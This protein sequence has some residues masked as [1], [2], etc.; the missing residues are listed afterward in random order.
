MGQATHDLGIEP[1]P[2]E[3]R[4]AL[5]QEIWD[6]VAVEAGLS[7]STP[8]ELGVLE[9][10]VAEDDASP[11]DVIAWERIKDEAVQRWRR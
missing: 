10:R 1:M 4:I 5:D 2:L 6:S 7:S 9:Q 3:Q 11:D 8:A